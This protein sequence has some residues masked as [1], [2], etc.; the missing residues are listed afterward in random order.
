MSDGVDLLLR[1]KIG[2][3]IYSFDPQPGGGYFIGCGKISIAS[4]Q[5]RQP[6][7]ADPFDDSGNE[8]IATV[9]LIIGQVNAKESLNILILRA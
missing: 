5:A 3:K 1:K 7:F 6:S 9:D 2:L 4:P 8:F